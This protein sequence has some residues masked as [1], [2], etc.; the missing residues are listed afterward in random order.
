[1]NIVEKNPSASACNALAAFRGGL[2]EVIDEG[3]EPNE[4]LDWVATDDLFQD[5]MIQDATLFALDRSTIHTW[6]VIIVVIAAV[7]IVTAA[8]SGCT[9]Q[10]TRHAEMELDLY[11][12]R[13]IRETGTV[14]TYLHAG[15]YGN[16][17]YFCW[18]NSGWD[19]VATKSIVQCRGNSFWGFNTEFQIL[20]TKGAKVYIPEAED[21]GI[22][23]TENKD[24]IWDVE[25]R[26]LWRV[27]I[28]PTAPVGKYT[29]TLEKDG[30]IKT[31]PLYVRFNDWDT[32]LAPRYY[33]PY[34]PE[35]T[36]RIDAYGSGPG[37]AEDRSKVEAYYYGDNLANSYS[38]Y[39]NPHTE[40]VCKIGIAA[41]SGTTNPY[42]GASKLWEFTNKFVDG[43]W[44]PGAT[45]A[46]IDIGSVDK[47]LETSGVTE[48]EVES[49]NIKHTITGQCMDFAF[50]LTALSRSIGIPA[51]PASGES[52]YIPGGDYQPSTDRW[53]FHVWTEIWL[54]DPPEGTDN[55]YVFDATD[56]VGS[57]NGVRDSRLDYGATW[58]PYKVVVGSPQSPTIPLIESTYYGI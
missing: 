43:Y 54:D 41:A 31:M 58:D 7:V 53:N 33:G 15:G 5:Y 45:V 42:D 25:K 34:L 8:S 12:A 11:I 40:I 30:K 39:L 36:A 19:T 16:E 55:W 21:N 4:F 2:S 3:A 49:G 37:Y 6:V 13:W 9:E 50:I 28:P 24:P 32:D 17:D 20:G 1:M 26:G 56:N 22:T 38:Q 57:A 23:L 14:E 27:I 51:R 18:E 48:D 10:E 52:P 35:E 46:I 29:I 44:G 47:I